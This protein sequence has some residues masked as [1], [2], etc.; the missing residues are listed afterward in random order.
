MSQHSDRM[1]GHAGLVFFSHHLSAAVILFVHA[2]FTSAVR[3]EIREELRTSARLFQQ[4]P[5]ESSFRWSKAVSQGGNIVQ[6]MCDVRTHVLNG[7]M[8]RRSKI[9]RRRWK[10]SRLCCWKFDGIQEDKTLPRSRSASNRYLPSLR[11]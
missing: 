2:C 11:C 4:V 9:H 6:V 5:P 1:H 10:I 3:P 7:L 8:D